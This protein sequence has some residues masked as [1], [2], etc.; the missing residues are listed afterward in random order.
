[1][2]STNKHNKETISTGNT[3]NY[4]KKLDFSKLLIDW[5][6]Y[7]IKKVSNS[8]NEGKKLWINVGTS[9]PIYY[10]EWSWWCR[11]WAYVKEKN[12]ILIFD[13]ADTA[14]LK[15]EI[16]HSLEYKKPIQ[17]KLYEFYE[18]VKNKISEK[19]FDGTT[20]SFNFKK[21][22]HEFIADG[23]CKYPFIK[24]LK[25]EWFYEEFLEKTKYIFE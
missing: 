17:N 23:Y 25:K 24:A 2:H 20:V 4:T 19:S 14:T 7:K 3:F 15:H 10:I 13:N 5:I 16:I 21:N 1:M 18:L 22:I 12:I 9:V 8:L 11:K 6:D